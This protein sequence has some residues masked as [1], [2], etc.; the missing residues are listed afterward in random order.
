MN[1]LW[2]AWAFGPLSS[3]RARSLDHA[4]R[5]VCRSRLACVCARVPAARACCGLLHLRTYVGD[6]AT[7][8]HA[9]AF[10]ESPNR[11]RLVHS[12]FCAFSPAWPRIKQQRA[13]VVSTATVSLS[14]THSARPTPAHVQ[15]PSLPHGAV[16]LA[17]VFRH[18]A[19]I[20][21]VS[22]V[23]CH[24]SFRCPLRTYAR[25]SERALRAWR[26][27]TDRPTL[28]TEGLP[29]CMPQANKEVR[30]L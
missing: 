28:R 23:F 3:P 11:S 10:G 13:C 15:P 6:E 26:V 16:S 20:R 24:A 30:L 12:V 2:D 29:T 14:C 22:L 9:G 17:C 18:G 25:T 1:T 5:L 19:R 8:G 27:C 7:M 21:S 4:R